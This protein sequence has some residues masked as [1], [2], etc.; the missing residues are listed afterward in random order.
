MGGNKDNR[1]RS[2]LCPMFSAIYGVEGVGWGQRLGLLSFKQKTHSMI[3]KNTSLYFS[4]SELDLSTLLNYLHLHLHL[5]FQ[6][7]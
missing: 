5:H 6:L 4:I 2:I 7:R 3:K 1:T